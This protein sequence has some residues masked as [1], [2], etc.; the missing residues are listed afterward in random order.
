[1]STI[2]LEHNLYTISRPLNRKQEKLLEKY[3]VEITAAQKAYHLILK[4]TSETFKPLGEEESCS[5]HKILA[6][7][8]GTS[9][10]CVLGVLALCGPQF[11]P[12]CVGVTSAFVVYMTALT[13]WERGKENIPS[14]LKSPEY[15]E[16]RDLMVAL[17]KSEMFDRLVRADEVLKNFTCPITKKLPL[18]PVN[19]VSPDHPEY[20]S[21]ITYDYN[22]VVGVIHHE[23]RRRM[24][25]ACVHLPKNYYYDEP[26]FKEGE[27]HYDFSHATTI[28]VR[29]HGLINLV[30]RY[31][32]TK[33]FVSSPINQLSNNRWENTSHLET[34]LQH[35]EEETKKHFDIEVHTTCVMI[36]SE[37]KYKYEL[38]K[39]FL[40]DNT[41]LEKEKFRK[42]AK[43]CKVIR[44]VGCS[45]LGKPKLHCTL[46]ISQKTAINTV[47]LLQNY[48]F[49][50][51]HGPLYGR[52][53]PE[54][55]RRAT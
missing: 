28:I 49:F 2:H 54:S 34:P 51:A 1:M 25:G 36:E 20:S 21:R 9:A 24:N 5:P 22:A 31:V 35:T 15:K 37:G 11:V 38:G 3:E 4:K 18:I 46:D 14:I 55:I 48:E 23:E 53:V 44:K 30:N 26:S 41:F 33:F 16:Y 17:N 29:T 45:L 43:T 27:L 6:G 39:R 42:L 7:T 19:N 10:V 47:Y 52:K 12:A 40:D 50:D 32:M 8:I 13:L